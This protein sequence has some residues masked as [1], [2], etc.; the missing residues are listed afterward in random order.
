[1]MSNDVDLEGAEK[2]FYTP[3][4]KPYYVLKTGEIYDPELEAKR[5]ARRLQLRALLDPNFR[6]MATR[7]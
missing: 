3:S 4:G 5:A 6:H 2:R 1:M 7:Q